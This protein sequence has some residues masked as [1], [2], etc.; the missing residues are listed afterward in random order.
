[1]TDHL[2]LSSKIAFLT[3]SL[4]TKWESYSQSLIKIYFP[5]CQRIVVDGSRSWNPIYFTDYGNK[6]H[7]DYLILVDEDCFI[8][9]RSQMVFLIQSL[10]H[11]KDCAL[12]ATPDGGT[13]HR[14]YNPIA[15]NTFFAIIKRQA[16]LRIVKSAGWKNSKYSDISDKVDDNHLEFL[17]KNRVNYDKH[18]PYY[19]FFWALLSNNFTIKYL[20]PSLNRSL[21]ASEVK[22]EKSDNPLLIHMWW[23]RSWHCR[24]IEPYLKVANYDRYVILEKKYLINIFKRP[25]NYIIFLQQNMIRLTKKIVYKLRSYVFKIS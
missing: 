17:D 14:D 22:I 23:L 9:S 5:E 16:L 25:S 13:Y 3:V 12:I 4:G 19:P 24:E 20:V 7:A 21:L 2:N 8:F 10:D 18:E 15:C 11:D 1:M 6:I